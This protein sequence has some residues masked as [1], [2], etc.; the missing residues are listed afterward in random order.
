MPTV[1]PGALRET[2]KTPRAGFRSGKAIGG[3]ITGLALPWILDAGASY[4]GIN[5]ETDRQ[6]AA[7]RAR[8]GAFEVG[9]KLS[10]LGVK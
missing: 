5:P 9:D 10:Q 2:L 4:M 1:R 3:G 8:M 6:D 7:A